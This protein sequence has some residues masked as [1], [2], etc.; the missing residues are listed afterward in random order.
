MEY[1]GVGACG[2]RQAELGA[3]LA[4]G[5]SAE[6]DVSPGGCSAHPV[7]VRREV[8]LPGEKQRERRGLEM[9]C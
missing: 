1:E 2:R 6:Q 7:S 3:A 9:G 5:G 4:A 8:I